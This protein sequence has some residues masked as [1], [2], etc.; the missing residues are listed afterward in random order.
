MAP[1]HQATISPRKDELIGPWIHARPWWD[2]V[3][4]RG[5]VGAFRR[6]DPAG[7]VGIE[8]FLSGSG[9]VDGACAG[10]TL[11]VPVTYRGAPLP[12]AAA[13]QVGTLPGRATVGPDLRLAVV[14]G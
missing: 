9:S 12:G 10:S 13:H 8:C 14:S 2:G 1:L 3:V 6:G 7:Q 11:F 5:S 4:E